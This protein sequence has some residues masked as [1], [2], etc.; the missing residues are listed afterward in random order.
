VATQDRGKVNSREGFCNICGEFRKLSKDHVPPKGCGNVGRTEV[1]ELIDALGAELPLRPRTKQQ[2][3]AHHRTLCENC[4]NLLGSNYDPELI[5]FSASVRTIARSP[6]V[7]PRILD[8]P[9]IPGRLARSVVGH[10]LAAGP[11]ETSGPTTGT[12]QAGLSAYVLDESAQ[13]PEQLDVY[14]WLYPYTTQ[15]AISAA[16]LMVGMGRA[17]VVIGVLKFFPVGFLLAWERPRGMRF[18]LA[19]LRPYH[20]Q[21]GMSEVLLPLALKPVLR[22][23]FPEGPTEDGALLY[24]DACGTAS[25]AGR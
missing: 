24:N 22:E 10:V 9:C 3:G 15:V 14:Y 20:R 4:N 21:D 17:F 1:F 11:R 23:K 16:G 2:N 19:A 6:L 8:I 5:R 7:L 13:F 25:R 12:M 18:N